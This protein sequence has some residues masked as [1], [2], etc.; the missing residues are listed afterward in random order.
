ME[1]NFIQIKEFARELLSLRHYSRGPQALIINYKMQPQQ[2][3]VMF[4]QVPPVCQ[5]QCQEALPPLPMESTSDGHQ[6]GHKA[7][8]LRVQALSTT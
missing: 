2:L 7:Q 5:A 4:N 8:Q 1:K 3:A 6:T